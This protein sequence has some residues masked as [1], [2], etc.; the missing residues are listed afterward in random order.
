MMSHLLIF[1]QDINRTKRASSFTHHTFTPCAQ[2]GTLPPSLIGWRNIYHG[3]TGWLPQLFPV[4]K[5]SAVLLLTL[6]LKY[7]FYSPSLFF[8]FFFL[9]S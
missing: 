9:T 8:L 2:T 6:P 5:P 1:E 4:Y 7:D 3:F